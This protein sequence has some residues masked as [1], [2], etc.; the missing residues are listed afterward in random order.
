MI[1]HMDTPAKQIPLSPPKLPAHQIAAL[2]AAADKLTA[3]RD[4]GRAVAHLDAELKNAAKD[5]V[6]GRITLA[7]AA[8]ATYLLSTPGHLDAAQMQLRGLVSDCE[9]QI[10]A[11]I[12]PIVIE[13][14][15]QQLDEIRAKAS[16][17]EQSERKAQLAAGLDPDDFKPSET[18]N[19]IRA[20]YVQELQRSGDPITPSA[21]RA[22]VAMLPTAH[23]SLEI[24]SLLD[25]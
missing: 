11:E 7:Q 17:L 8:V 20:F 13:I 25:E 16:K 9:L 4:K 10:M 1:N 23:E 6:D 14:R 3:T 12:R 21:L 19:G 15:R 18:L 5:F 22:I 2:R 24:E